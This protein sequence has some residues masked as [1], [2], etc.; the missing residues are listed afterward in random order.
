MNPTIEL[1]N[2]FSSN[3]IGLIIKVLQIIALVL[4]VLYSF[5][6]IRQVGIMNHTLM[7]K[8]HFELKVA[9]Y[10]QAFLGIGVLILILIR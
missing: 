10:L 4:F 3:S 2:I 6:T 1:A 7:N 9:A 5:L 8:F